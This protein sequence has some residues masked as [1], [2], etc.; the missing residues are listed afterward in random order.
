MLGNQWDTVDID[1]LAD[2][3]KSIDELADLEKEG[4]E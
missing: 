4:E 2:P 1:E 3:E